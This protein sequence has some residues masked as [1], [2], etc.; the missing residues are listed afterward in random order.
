MTPSLATARIEDPRRLRLPVLP[1]SASPDAAGGASQRGSHR[2]SEIEVCPRLWY[3]HNVRQLEPIQEHRY[4]GRSYAQEGSL[5]HLQLA[6]YYAAR[7]VNP[8]RWY[9]TVPLDTAI[10][11]VGTGNPEATRL[12]YEFLAAYAQS[13]YGDRWFPVAV[14]QEFAARVGDIRRVADPDAK[15]EPEDDQIVTS[16][17]D[18][19]VVSNG[20]LWLVDYK[21]KARG[22]KDGYLSPWHDEGQFGLVWQFYVQ[23]LVVRAAL[24][25]D[26]R[27]TGE[28]VPDLGGVIVHRY[29]LAPP[30]DTSA[31]PAPFSIQVFRDAADSILR[32]VRAETQLITDVRFARE[33][34]DDMETWLPDGFFWSCYMY[35]RPCDFRPLC[36]TDRSDRGAW[37][38]VMRNQ[39]KTR[40][41]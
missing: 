32:Q 35:G 31:D 40:G 21:G 3:L 37:L 34:E 29:K 36:L 38:A 7:M 6:Y 19:C 14:E 24:V 25:A 5:S 22:T 18:L 8:P 17:I 39:Y 20:L 11:K 1:E 2:L 12:S 9:S 27:L 15:P 30:W 4:R 23:L 28:P 10:A 33:Y 13:G 26:A 41:T 16:R